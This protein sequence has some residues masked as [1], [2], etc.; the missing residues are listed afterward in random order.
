MASNEYWA[1]M[2][3]EDWEAIDAAELE[4]FNAE[5]DARDAERDQR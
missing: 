3:N 1:E 4:Q 2:T 5:Q